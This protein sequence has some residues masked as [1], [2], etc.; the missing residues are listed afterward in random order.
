M[1]YFRHGNVCFGMLYLK[2]VG[3]LCVFMTYVRL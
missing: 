2:G 3:D 1:T